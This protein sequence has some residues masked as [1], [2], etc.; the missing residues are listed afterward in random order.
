MKGF[1]I[2]ILV[3][4]V[5]IAVSIGWFFDTRPVISKTSELKV[6]DNIDYYLSGVH[7]KAF[8]QDGNPQ[9]ILQSPYL[10]HFIRE[11]RSDIN[12]PA[13][14]YY[15]DDQRWHILARQ[16]S[17][18]HP[19]EIFQLSHQ[20]EMQRLDEIDPI[21]LEAELMEFNPKQ[22]LVNI[23]QSLTLKTDELQLQAESAIFDLQNKRHQLNRVQAS[24]QRGA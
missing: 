2:F 19:T 9:Y 8:D 10:E 14:Q 3:I 12:Q 22:D 15:S 13:I 16:G 24:Y 17:L 23:P 1:H 7:F 11:D 6:P 21:Q 5:A 4:G 20:V 18:H